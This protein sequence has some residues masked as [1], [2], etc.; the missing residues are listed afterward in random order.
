MKA[1]MNKEIVEVN[2]KAQ[3]EQ[4]IG[5]YHAS[6][7]SL[8]DGVRALNQKY[9]EDVRAN[10]YTPEYLIHLAPSTVS[11][12]SHSQYTVGAAGVRTS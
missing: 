6:Q 4:L 12:N 10:T 5:E 3:L 2:I 8:A 7:Q 11:W 9:K 1:I